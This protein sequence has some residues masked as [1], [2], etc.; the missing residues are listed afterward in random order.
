GQGAVE[1]PL[2]QTD[3]ASIRIRRSEARIDAQRRGVIRSR[4]GRVAAQMAHKTSIAERLGT[5]WIDAERLLE[6][7]QRRRQLAR[8][9]ASDATV[10][11]LNGSLVCLH[12]GTGKNTCTYSI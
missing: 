11:Q 7:R 8:D 5:T 10:R 12:G 9:G 4:T 2:G 1:V 3:T 6:V